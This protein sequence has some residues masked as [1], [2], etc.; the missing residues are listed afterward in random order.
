MGSWISHGSSLALCPLSASSAKG[1]I[2]VYHACIWTHACLSFD[3]LVDFGVCT[4][5][6]WLR[7]SVFLSSERRTNESCEKCGEFSVEWMGRGFDGIFFVCLPWTEA[8]HSNALLT[9]SGMQINEDDKHRKSGY[10]PEKHNN[11]REGRQAGI[12]PRSNALRYVMAHNH[13]C[14]TAP[15]VSVSPF[16]IQARSFSDPRLVNIYKYIYIKELNRDSKRSRQPNY[17]AYASVSRRARS[18]GSQQGC[19]LFLAQCA[20]Y[21]TNSVAK[22]RK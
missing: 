21:W 1:E 17:L 18:H 22:V 2:S 4:K 11:A 9:T 8:I 20:I 19:M 5:L 16:S 13:F 7:I 15:Q 10:V 6:R 3:P 14:K 12:D